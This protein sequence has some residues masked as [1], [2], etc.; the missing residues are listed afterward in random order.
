VLLQRAVEASDGERRRIAATLHDGVVQE[1]A[2]SSFALGGAAE[3]ADRSRA[4]ELAQTLRGAAETVRA[5]IKGLRSLLVEIY[6][7]SLQ[8]S[9]LG[10]AL[11][12]LVGGLAVRG[13]RV[14]LEVADEAIVGLT[15][16]RQQ[17][18][19]RVAQETLRNAVAHA[20]AD[21]VVLRL[22]RVGAQVV[23]EVSDDGDGFDVPTI[24]SA[25]A[26]GHFGVRLLIDV[27]SSA[28]ASLEV[29]SAPGHGCEWRLTVPQT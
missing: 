2:A 3:R 24:L 21:E 1:L 10:A 12:D 5:S 8:T 22:S 11:T 26:E 13:A 9:G 4:P 18:I 7:P 16:E 29:R 19:Y 15:A 17:L 28:G 14:R 20:N 6:P 23:L 27:A 25:P